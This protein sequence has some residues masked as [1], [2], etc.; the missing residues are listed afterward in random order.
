M[1]KF[2]A[3]FEESRLKRRW[4]AYAVDYE[5][6]KL[7]L[8]VAQT[9]HYA[10]PA[11]VK[12]SNFGRDAS[13]RGLLDFSSV[14]AEGDDDEAAPRRGAGHWTRALFGV[15]DASCAFLLHG[16]DVALA[17]EVAEASR[18]TAARSRAS[19]GAGALKPS[20]VA[21]ASGPLRLS[22]AALDSEAREL[23][24]FRAW[25]LVAC[26]KICKKRDKI[27]KDE[28]PIRDRVRAA[29]DGRACWVPGS[30][31]ALLRDLAAAFGASRAAPPASGQKG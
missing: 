14:V 11:H 2:G 3:R 29:L 24:D 16:F 4:S 19:S 1:V 17:G 27:F 9:A 6:L 26:G 5:R 23:V 7:L 10:K 15:K 30:L 18:S 8:K 22:L 21:K 28:A 31:D 20:C 13:S 12:L 25:N